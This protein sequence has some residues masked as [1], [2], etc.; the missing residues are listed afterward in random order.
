MYIDGHLDLAYNVLAAGR[1][2]TLTLDALRAQGHEDALVTLPELTAGKVGLVFGTI[3]VRPA[4]SVPMSARGGPLTG[5]AYETPAEARALGLAQLELYERWEE[6]GHIRIVRN[7]GDLKAYET[8]QPYRNG[9]E[10]A[11]PGVVLLLEGADPLVTPDDLSEWCGRGLRL[12]GPAWQR[13]RY[14]GGTKAPGPLTDLGRE[15]MQALREQHVTLDVSH[16]AEESFWEALELGPENVIAS[17][18]NARAFVPTDRH[19]SDEMIRA[20]GDKDG[21]IGLVIANPFLN[22]ATTDTSP[23]TDTTLAQVAQHAEHIA[24]LIG[25]DKV[26]VGTDWDGG[27]GVADIPAELSRAADFGQLG[28]AVPAAARAGFLGDNWLRL[29]QRTLPE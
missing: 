15:L 7:R 5:K 3:Y 11:V 17:H 6:Q 12:L 20:L 9:A 19:L 10:N 16:L 2:L 24:G 1:E 25:W 18:S 26:A 8:G 22:A 29:L 4:A 13:T 28:E 21:V 27:F 14:S 23:K